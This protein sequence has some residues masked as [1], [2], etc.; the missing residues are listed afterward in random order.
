MDN[1]KTNVL[2]L[3]FEKTI[4]NHIRERILLITEP[5]PEPEKQES[6]YSIIFIL[7]NVCYASLIT[8]VCYLH[9]NK[10]SL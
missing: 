3:H 1:N 8:G 9:E 2:W 10:M 5:E 4:S 6:V 7:Y